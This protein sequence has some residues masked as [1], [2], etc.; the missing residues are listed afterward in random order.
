MKH[1]I[2]CQWR[3][4]RLR[5][6]WN[7]MHQNC[8]CSVRDACLVFVENQRRSL[9]HKQICQVYT[10]NIKVFSSSIVKTA[11]TFNNSFWLTPTIDRVVSHQFYAS[12]QLAALNWTHAILQNFTSS[13]YSIKKKSTNTLTYLMSVFFGRF[14][15]LK[16][17]FPQKVT[18]VTEENQEEVRQIGQHCHLERS[19]F[20]FLH[21]RIF[22]FP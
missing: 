10:L 11:S 4:T 8:L 1:C 15:F 22:E 2:L 19:I 18:Q 13:G 9:L 7:Q 16:P 12:G 14:W 6:C 20:K 17:V 3:H 21:K 5:Q